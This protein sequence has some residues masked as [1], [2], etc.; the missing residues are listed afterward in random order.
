[1]QDERVL[2]VKPANAATVAAARARLD[3]ARSI[4]DGAIDLLPTNGGDTRMA[5]AEVDA[6]LVD[7]KA[8]KRALDDL[9][10]DPD[11]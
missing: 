7:L 8:A 6:A 10:A 1:M 9:E 11:A 2:R 3:R 5:S 4:L